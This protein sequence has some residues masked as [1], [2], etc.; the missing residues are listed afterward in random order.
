[1]ATFKQG[2]HG[3]FSGTVGNV[4]GSSWKG[5][6]VMKI[7]PASVSNPNTEGQ[8]NQRG[9]FGTVVRFL[10]A[11]NQLV[12]SGFR[13][14]ANGITTFN[15]AMSYNLANAITGELPD[16]RIDFPKAMISKGDLPGVSNLAATLPSAG[17]LRLE[18]T[19]ETLL[20]GA[21]PT[22]KLMLSVYNEEEG[23]SL[24]YSSVASRSAGSAEIGLPSEWTGKIVQILVFLI[25][26]KAI[27][28]VETRSEVSDTI[29]AG[30]LQL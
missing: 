18:W 13:P 24:I 27:G 29:W 25:A 21:A 23:K 5:T 10:Q 30:E 15:A 20:S 26:D 2:I 8:R 7:R 4:V 9:R 17:T 14:W 19:A 3:N 16:L 6:G 12:R 11:H 22:D 28:S 1:M